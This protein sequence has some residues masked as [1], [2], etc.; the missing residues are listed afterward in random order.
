MSIGRCAA[1]IVI[2]RLQEDDL[3]VRDEIRGAVLLTEPS[4]PVICAGVAEGLRFTESLVGLSH[5][6]FYKLRDLLGELA[7][8]LN[9]VCEIIP[10]NRGED[11]L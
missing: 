10:K 7:I 8:R 1:L 4:R 6:G 3:A 9:P 2:A 11:A 5:H